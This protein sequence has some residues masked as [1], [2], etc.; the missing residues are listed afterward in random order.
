MRH[1]AIAIAVITVA[2]LASSASAAMF[3]SSVEL[4]SQGL[5][6]ASQPIEAARSNPNLALGAPQ[7]NDTMNFVSLGFGGSITL[8]FASP[9]TLPS[10]IVIETTYGN[11]AGHPEA[12]LV[13]VGVGA[14][15]ASATYY[16]V[17]Q[18]LNT[19]DSVP[20]SL[21]PVFD[22]FGVS[23]FNYLRIVDNTRAIYPNGSSTDGFDV[24]GVSVN[25]IPTPGA[26]ALTGLSGLVGLRRRR[27]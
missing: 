14:D 17:G 15:A 21:Q 23:V 7:N 10:A 5:N 27:K 22:N 9:F 1:T 13:Y 20:L 2:G 19:T 4:F 3:A 16:L 8:G 26:L 18:A 11:P 6:S 25:P 24:D 12:A